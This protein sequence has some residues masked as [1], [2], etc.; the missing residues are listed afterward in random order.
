[1]AGEVRCTGC[2]VLEIE[3]VHTGRNPC[4]FSV[5]FHGDQFY[6]SKAVEVEIEKG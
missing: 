3:R 4:C 2:L 5:N 6:Q 1:M